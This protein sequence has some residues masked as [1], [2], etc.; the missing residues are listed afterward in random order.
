MNYML[1]LIIFLIACAHS[2]YAAE[3]ATWPL[4]VGE[5]QGTPASKDKGVD[6]D[7]H[8]GFDYGTDR[9]GAWANL[10]I[11]N[12]A[13][14][15]LSTIE[16]RYIEIQTADYGNG[17]LTSGVFE[18]GAP[19]NEQGALATEI[20]RHAVTA[21]RINGGAAFWIAAKECSQET[22]ES[23]HQVAGVP[24]VLAA[25][26]LDATTAEK[27]KIETVA[28]LEGEKRVR[29]IESQ[30]LAS[31]K[32]FTTHLQAQCGATVRL[33]QE[34]EWE[35]VCR[36]GTATAFWSGRLLQSSGDMSLSGAIVDSEMLYAYSRD[37]M[38]ANIKNNPWGDTSNPTVNPPW[39]V[40]KISS[41]DLD[42]RASFNRWNMKITIGG[43]LTFNG[44]TLS[45]SPVNVFD[46]RFQHRYRADYYGA[47]SPI[48]MTYELVD[49]VYEPRPYADI[50]V[51]TTY[52]RYLDVGDAIDPSDFIVATSLNSANSMINTRYNHKASPPDKLQSSGLVGDYHDGRQLEYREMVH[53]LTRYDASGN[54]DSAGAYLKD[55]N[56]RVYPIR[57]RY[58][59]TPVWKSGSEMHSTFPAV[60]YDYG[61][62]LEKMARA[63]NLNALGDPDMNTDEY[64]QTL[65]EEIELGFDKQ[66]DYDAGFYTGSVAGV[67]KFAGFNEG[68]PHSRMYDE[69]EF[70]EAV[71][72]TLDV[73]ASAG[74]NPWGLY[75]V[76]GNV[77]EWVDTTWDGLSNSKDHQTGPYQITRGGSWR[78][79]ADKCRSAA[80]T[81]RDPDSAYDDVGFRFIIEE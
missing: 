54:E 75:D 78:T 18:M 68:V 12:A 36:A 34:E 48:L 30:T 22:W 45:L 71:P 76:H 1:S 15:V 70:I 40:G 41:V 16:M 24:V 29:A 2:L 23:V 56:G 73:D 61:P 79:G 21:A 72:P 59:P 46:S 66:G 69:I 80:R 42:G 13:G 44:G 37:D 35:Y 63:T 7:D 52:F 47:Y 81:A 9:W 14:D 17:P 50:T 8:S 39:D 32:D 19:E 26:D 5:D 51:A 28:F 3:P 11:K 27:C 53:V 64:V 49:S 65:K 31:V 55:F 43:K 57:S 60:G 58:H 67:K 10:E 38:R 25:L 20:P 77:E 4:W 33:P 62:D 6:Q 74:R